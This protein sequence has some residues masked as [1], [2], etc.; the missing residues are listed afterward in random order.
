M[1]GGSMVFSKKEIAPDT[2]GDGVPM[3]QTCGLHGVGFTADTILL[4]IQEQSDHQVR[5]EKICSSVRRD[6]TIGIMEL[7][8]LK[9]KL[10][11]AAV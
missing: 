9:F 11:R 8:V 7:H 3:D 1:S 5:P 4:S 6:D 2:G 10:G